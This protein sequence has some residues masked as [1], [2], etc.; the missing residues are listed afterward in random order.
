MNLYICVNFIC[1]TLKFGAQYYTLKTQVDS[2]IVIKIVS[3]II[4]FTK[5][6]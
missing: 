2:Y 5:I 1:L 3:L 4:F 6:I